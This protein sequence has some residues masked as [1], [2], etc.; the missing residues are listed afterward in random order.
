MA[1]AEVIQRPASLMVPPA[2]VA[3]TVCEYRVEYGRE[4]EA[5]QFEHYDGKWN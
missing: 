3:T 2:P 4:R 5:E 1:G